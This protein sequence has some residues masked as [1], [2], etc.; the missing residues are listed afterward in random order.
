MR[1]QNAV[2]VNGKTIIV[3]DSGWVFICQDYTDAGDQ[4]CL[5]DASVIRVWGTEAGLGQIALKGPTK[6]TILD[7]CGNPSVPKN[8]VLFFLPCVV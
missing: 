4:W 3:V 5:H 7:K 2:V 1:K 6:E 8:K